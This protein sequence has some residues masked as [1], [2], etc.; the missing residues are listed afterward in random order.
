MLNGSF[1]AFNIDRLIL[2]LNVVLTKGVNQSSS[3][4]SRVVPVDAVG[5]LKGRG[6]GGLKSVFPHSGS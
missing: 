3:S 2:F 5:D 1:L 6:R 4:V